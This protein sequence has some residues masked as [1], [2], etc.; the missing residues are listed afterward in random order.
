[1][2]NMTAKREK[3]RIDD[4]LDGKERKREMVMN[5]TTKREKERG[6][7]KKKRPSKDVFFNL[8]G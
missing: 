3:E 1:M 8:I 5:K 4:E 2:M 7:G 6:N